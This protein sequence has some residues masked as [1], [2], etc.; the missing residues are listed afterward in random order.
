MSNE[1]NLS[2]KER[3][4]RNCRIVSKLILIVEIIMIIGPILLLIAALGVGV[5]IYTNSVE[6]EVIV[7]E[8]NYVSG[9]VEESQELLD[10]SDDGF[11]KF[12]S[13]IF[14]YLLAFEILDI[15][16]RMLKNVIKDETPF[17]EDNLKK[18]KQIDSRMM[19][20]LIISRSIFSIELIYVILVSSIYLIFKYGYELQVESDETL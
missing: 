2:T 16:R 5:D 19:L 18:I 9:E 1:K 17:S 3:M 11:I 14:R 10:E 20:S 4:I 15:I 8:E 12:I 7:M 13:D 6:E